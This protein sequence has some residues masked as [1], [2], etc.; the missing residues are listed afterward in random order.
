MLRLALALTF[1]LAL[2]APAPASAQQFTGAGS[3]FAYQLLVRWSQAYQR[4]QRDAEYQPV[5]ALFD[6]EAIGS[7]AGIQRL[8]ERAVDFGATEVPLSDEEMRR[9]NAAQFPIVAGGIAVVVNIAGLAPGRLKLTGEVVADIYQGKITRWSDPAIRALNADLALPDAPIAPVRRIDGSGTTATFTAYLS[10][11]SEGWRGSVGQGQTV[12][13]PAGAG[14]RGNLGVATTVR[15][16]PN[17]IGYVDVATS[18]AM[19]LAHAL[20][21]NRAGAFVGPELANLQAALASGSAST[22]M[23]AALIDAPGADAYPILATVFVALPRE[24]MASGRTRAMLAFFGW[25]LEHGSADAQALGYVA[26]PAEAMTRV[27]EGW[28]EVA[29]AMR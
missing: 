10:K 21:R 7:E 22:D 28:R 25:S 14:A 13:W 3:T 16:T 26:L 15:N 11:A 19:A 8:R 4:S 5:G 1:G 12:R 23:R 29:P 24:A 6:Y 27:R 18:R 2:L 20:V 9:Y 17:A